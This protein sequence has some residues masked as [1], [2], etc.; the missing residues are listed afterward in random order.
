[1]T[2]CSTCVSGFAAAVALIAFF[3]DLAFF[4]L[5][6]S[7]I[8]AVKGGSAT[9]G[10]AIWLTLAAWILLFFSGCFYSIGRCCI[11]NR[12][13]RNKPWDRKNGDREAGPGGDGYAGQ[14]RLDAVK[15]E[16]DRKA[17]QSQAEVGLPSFQEHV[18]LKK[19][20]S[21]DEVHLMNDDHHDYN[22]GGAAAGYGRRPSQ[23]SGYAGYAQAPAGTRAVDEYYN[24]TGDQTGSSYPP[25]PQR[26]SSGHTLGPSGYT[27]AN[28]AYAA[29]GPAAGNQYLAVGQQHGQDR[30]ST[31]NDYGH[32]AG[33]TTCELSR[34]LI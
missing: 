27:P 2:C 14:M 33:G 29:P 8:N 34:H 30:Y 31:P 5:A 12:G 23:N 21:S 20:I 7:R 19:S 11:S 6:K 3:F 10:N 24:P 4:F 32:T 15:A 26:Q 9:I 22:N 13:P 25:Q 18:P 28:N 1:M 17:K 16:A